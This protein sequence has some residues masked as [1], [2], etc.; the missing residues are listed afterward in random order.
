M[1]S[2]WT[3][4]KVSAFFIYFCI[5]LNVGFILHGLMICNQFFRLRIR[6]F[7]WFNFEIGT[8]QFNLETFAFQISFQNHLLFDFLEWNHHSIH[9]TKIGNC[10]IN[11]CQLINK[12]GWFVMPDQTSLILRMIH[13]ISVYFIFFLLHLWNCKIR[14]NLDNLL[15][16]AERVVL[17]IGIREICWNGI[18]IV[19]VNFLGCTLG[20]V[21]SNLLNAS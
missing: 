21:Q 18:I 5:E 20:N 10:L 14:N 19:S 13:S 15:E 3:S 9:C 2:F 8:K 16:W 11:C 1:C 17:N 7:G 6:I 12:I 4:S